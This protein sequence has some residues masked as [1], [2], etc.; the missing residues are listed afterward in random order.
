MNFH[1][2]IFN[3]TIKSQSEL[4]LSPWKMMIMMVMVMMIENA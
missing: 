4:T 2:G 1:L 3:T